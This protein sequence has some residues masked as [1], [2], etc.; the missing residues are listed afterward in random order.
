MKLKS[1]IKQCKKDNQLAYSCLYDRYYNMLF[2]VC[3]RIVNNPKD[4]EDVLITSFTKIFASIKKV[5][6][7]TDASFI[8]WMKTIVVNE[9][10]RFYNAKKP[11]EFKNDIQEFESNNTVIWEN[12]DLDI[13]TV[14]LILSNLPKGYQLV[15]NLYAIEGYSH[16]EIANMLNITESTSKSQLRKAR[17]KIVEQ[18][19]IH[20]YEYK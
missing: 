19:K 9:S 17:I 10:I 5:D 3:R 12:V 1:I 20:S 11:I 18:L 7:R 15:F 14:Y 16:K 8:K 13:E 2:G 4:V 6:Y